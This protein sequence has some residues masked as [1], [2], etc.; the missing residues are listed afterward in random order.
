[1]KAGPCGYGLYR[2]II[3]CGHDCQVVASSLIPRK[4][5]ERIKTDKQDARKLSRYLLSPG[6][7]SGLALPITHKSETWEQT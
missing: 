4:P 5:G 2:Q 3:A 7:T 6:E 1:M